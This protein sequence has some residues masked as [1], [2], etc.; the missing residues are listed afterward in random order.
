MLSNSTI[1]KL[2]E[3]LWKEYGKEVNDKDAS[4][5]ANGLVN[6]F[7]LLGRIYHREKIKEETIEKVEVKN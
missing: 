5:I 2:Q 1:K 7:D 4:E 6:Y 3:I